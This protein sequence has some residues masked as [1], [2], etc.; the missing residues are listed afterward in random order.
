M[1]FYYAFIHETIFDY[2]IV[3]GTSLL[4]K[5]NINPQPS[6]RQLNLTIQSH[7]AD[8]GAFMIAAINAV[9]KYHQQTLNTSYSS[10]LKYLPSSTPQRAFQ[11]YCPYANSSLQLKL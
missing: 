7:L 4:S 3:Q 2:M 11:D 5:V 6:N 9:Q 1:L 10:T 8:M